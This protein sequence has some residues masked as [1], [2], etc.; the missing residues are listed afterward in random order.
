[1][2]REDSAAAVQL[3]GPQTGY[4]TSAISTSGSDTSNDAY[5]ADLHIFERF[6]AASLLAQHPRLLLTSQ[7]GRV[8][9]ETRAASVMNSSFFT[10]GPSKRASRLGSTAA[11]GSQYTSCS[12]CSKSPVPN[13]SN[14]LFHECGVDHAH[15]LRP[16]QVRS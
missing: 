9:A 14:V 11:F 4:S 13:V 12:S 3:A 8:V 7:Y 6:V 2:H 5:T 16:R 15:I 10:G 1:M